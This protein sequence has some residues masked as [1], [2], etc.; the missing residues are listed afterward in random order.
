[1]KKLMFIAMLISFALTAAEID[2]SKSTLSWKGS[3][4]A[5]GF[6]L[7]SHY[8][9]IKIKSG[10]FDVKDGKLVGGNVVV[11]MTD[12][13]VEDLS[14][15]WA[16]KFINHMK[17]SDFFK[18]EN[19]KTSELK[20]KKVSGKK[21]T[22]DLTINGKTNEVTFDYKKEGDAFVGQLLFDRTKFGMNYGD[23][24]SLGDKFIHHEVEV[25]FKIYTK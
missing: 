12:F 17:S 15:T 2:T 3:K 8:G 22:A 10:D 25:G 13:T 4:G 21:A 9:K 14:G 23:D 24:E 19:F 7:G 1:M 11:D 16:E 5:A 18:T 20:I 6:K